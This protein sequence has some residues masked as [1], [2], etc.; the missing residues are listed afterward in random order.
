MN[1]RIKD[2]IDAARDVR[3]HS[4]SPH[5]HFRVG[6]ALLGRSGVV[7]LGTNVENASLGLTICAERTA[8]CRA[9]TDGERDFVAIAVC[10]DGPEPTTPCGACRQVLLEF[11]PDLPVYAA[12]ERGSAGP[13]LETTTRELLAHAF[14]CI[15]TERK[16]DGS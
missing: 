2:L 16:D 7:Y 1:K 9:V 13:V 12:G 6:A 5:S 8:I 3:R 15:P 11:G 4:Y 14:T 10:A